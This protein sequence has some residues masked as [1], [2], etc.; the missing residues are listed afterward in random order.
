MINTAILGTM[1][2]PRK[3]TGSMTLLI[4]DS[5]PDSY[6]AVDIELYDSFWLGFSEDVDETTIAS[7][8]EFLLDGDPV[9]CT[10][11]REAEYPTYIDVYP[12]SK[13]EPESVYTIGIKSGL[14]AVS[15]N[16]IDQVYDIPFTTGIQTMDFISQDPNFISNE[17]LVDTTATQTFSFTFSNDVDPDTVDTTI[18][19][20][21]QTFLSINAFSPWDPRRLWTQAQLLIPTTKSVVDNVLT[22]TPNSNLSANTEFYIMVQNQREYPNQVTSVEG[23]PLD[24]YYSGPGGYFTTEVDLMKCTGRDPATDSVDVPLDKVATFTFDHNVNPASIVITGTHNNII[25]NRNN[26]KTINFSTTVVDN[27]LRITPTGGYWAANSTYIVYID[28]CYGGV[29]STEGYRLNQIASVT[30]TTASS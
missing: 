23:Y 5:W 4:E 3:S 25:I 14:K 8:I 13:M 11:E 27:E 22:I 24:R 19:G 21:V 9:A 7:N 29:S 16:F 12:T 28:A 18:D 1:L 26:V 20:N 17:V 30:F 10:I 15:G 6:D 2:G